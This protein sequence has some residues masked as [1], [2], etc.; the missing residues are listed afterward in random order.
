M[1]DVSIMIAKKVTFKISKA[2]TD[3]LQIP[4]VTTDFAFCNEKAV[5][6]N[7]TCHHEIS[8]SVDSK[9]LGRYVLE[10]LKATNI[11]KVA[12]IFQSERAFI[13]PISLHI[14]KDYNQ[15]G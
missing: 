7:A 8:M 6:H 2:V 11:S 15:C 14:I 13:L 3:I 1:S 9:N 12:V 10:F 5:G 4:L